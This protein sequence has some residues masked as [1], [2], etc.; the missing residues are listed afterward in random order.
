MEKN[1]LASHAFM[2]ALSVARNENEIIRFVNNIFHLVL[3]KDSEV[4]LCIIGG[5]VIEQVKK[6]AS[7]NVILTGRVADVKDA[8]GSCEVVCLSIAV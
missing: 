4:E 2:S 7:D 3:A 6:L 5:G 1:L 8:I